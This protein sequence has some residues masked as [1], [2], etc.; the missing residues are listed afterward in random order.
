[1]IF[2]N[3]EEESESKMFCQN[4]GMC[5]HTT[6]VCTILKALV[7]EAKRKEGAQFEKKE[8]VHQA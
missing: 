7:K 3:S 1:M 5:G 6:D 8:K 2:G 4:H